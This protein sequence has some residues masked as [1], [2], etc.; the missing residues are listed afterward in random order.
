MEKL[1]PIFQIE[2]KISA[3]VALSFD[4]N[5]NKRIPRDQSQQ[6]RKVST[7]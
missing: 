2:K 3:G 4:C 6:L 1:Y 7:L 5:A